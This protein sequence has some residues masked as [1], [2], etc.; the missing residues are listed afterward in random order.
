[1]IGAEDL[2]NCARYAQAAEDDK[3]DPG[4]AFGEAMLEYDSYGE[5][6]GEYVD[7]EFRDGNVFPF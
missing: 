3:V 4:S 7:C 1:M 6:D 5:N 2:K